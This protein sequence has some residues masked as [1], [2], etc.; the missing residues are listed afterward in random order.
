MKSLYVLVAIITLT[1]AMYAYALDPSVLLKPVVVDAQET[2]T[3]GSNAIE[4]GNN[5]TLTNPFYKGTSAKLLSQKVLDTTSNG[6]PQIELTTVQDATIEGV[7]NV[8]NLATWTIT[9]K[10]PKTA[11][12]TGKGVITADNGD[13]AT[14]IASDVGQADDKGVI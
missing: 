7:G 13:M 14:W 9:Y 2:T 4:V 6:L 11:Y 10:T 3:I 8:T 12:T 1:F 5:L